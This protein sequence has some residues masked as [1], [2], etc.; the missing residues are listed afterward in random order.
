M[1]ADAVAF[2][3]RSK[4]L[5]GII[6]AVTVAA[7]AVRAVVLESPLVRVDRL[8]P[9]LPGAGLAYLSVGDGGPRV[10]GQE[11]QGGGVGFDNP[12]AFPRRQCHG[13]GGV[14]AQHVVRVEV[15]RAVGGDVGEVVG[16]GR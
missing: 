10:S 6:A 1:P 3:G 12:A 11:P 13:Q 5:R 15:G 8:V 2:T 4:E 7:R 14:V 9:Q 16:L